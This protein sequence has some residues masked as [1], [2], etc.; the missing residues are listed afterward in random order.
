MIAVPNPALDSL[1]EH[2]HSNARRWTQISLGQKIDYLEAIRGNAARSA[3]EWVQLSCEAKQIPFDRPIAGEEWLSGPWVILGTI[4][5]LVQSLRDIERYGR[6]HYNPDRLRTLASGQISVEV[7]PYD[8]YDFLLLHGIRLEVWMQPG[9]TREELPNTQALH[10]R[11]PKPGLSLV[12]GAGNVSC[13]GP[14]D[15]LYKMFVENKVALLKMNPVLGYLTGLTRQ[16][17]GPLVEDGFLEV[18]EGDS[19]VGQYLCHHSQV[20]DIHITGSARTHDTIV[21]G[22]GPQGAARKEANQPVLQKP[23][24]SELGGVGPVIVVPGPWS[25]ADI[26][27][28]AEHIATMA[29]HNGG[30]DCIGAQVVLLPSD[31][32]HTP[33][34]SQA[35][36]KQFAKVPTRAP[37]YPGSFERQANFVKHHTQAELDLRPGTTRTLI[38]NLEPGRDEYAFEQEAFC[39]VLGETLLPGDAKGFLQ[40]AIELCNQRL[41]GSLGANILIHPKTLRQLGPEFERMLLELRYGCIAVNAWTAVAFLSARATWGAF[42]GHTLQDIQS[43]M[44]SVHN[45]LMFEHPE[46]TVVWG[47]F[48]PAPRS[49]A[50]GQFTIFPKPPWFLGHKRAHLIGPKVVEFTA[51]PSPFGLVKIFADALMG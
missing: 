38:P 13:L 15:V 30:F 21:F 36:R 48:Y 5:A 23:I 14:L 17:F 24:S 45:A 20:D 25:K 28:Q 27:F 6:P 43:G 16:V 8:L 37:Y 11:Q 34:L 50:H 9:I 26:E 29:L 46:R 42:P 18:L 3:G 2:L 49:F 31:W 10:Y 19:Q 40:A 35:V 41:M 32:K 1:L 51:S 7:Y 4:D 47:N 12:L 22:P 33:A 44:G 39:E